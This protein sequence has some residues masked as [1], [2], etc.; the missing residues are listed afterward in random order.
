MNVAELLAELES[1]GVS[2]VRDGDQM[3]CEGAG[4]SLPPELCQELQEHRDE[5]LE[6]LSRCGWC[7]APLVGSVKDYWRVV[8]NAG[9]SYLCSADCVFEA[10]P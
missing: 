1:R 10:W 6:A 9:V 7:R 2:L 3:R 5:L 8:R 4:A